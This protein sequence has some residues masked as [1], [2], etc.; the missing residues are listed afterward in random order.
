MA[1]SD[2]IPSKNAAFETFAVNFDTIGG[3]NPNAIGLLA[4]DFTALHPL[5]LAYSAA[6]AAAENPITRTKASVNQRN[7]CRAQLEASIRALVKRVQANNTVGSTAG[8]ENRTGPILT[9]SR[10]RETGQVQID[11][12]TLLML[13]LFR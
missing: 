2:Y 6:R 9:G 7:V 3:A 5:V 10:S 11:I 8:P 1:G 12:N 13:P 4:A